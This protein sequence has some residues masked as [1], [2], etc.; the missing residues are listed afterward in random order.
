MW[1]FSFVLLMAVLILAGLGMFAPRY[2][3]NLFQR[4]GLF[5][6]ILGCA[7]EMALL[8]ES[9]YVHPRDLIMHVGVFLFAVGTAAKVV[10][11]SF[12]GNMRA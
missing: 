8:M 11:F 12:R 1:M 9:Q 2:D 4:L 10:Y 6:L 5:A 3:D 7:S